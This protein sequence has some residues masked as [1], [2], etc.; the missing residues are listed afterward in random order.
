M[1]MCSLTHFVRKQREITDIDKKKFETYHS[2]SETRGSGMPRQ[3]E[4]SSQV[5][6]LCDTD[7]K[8][9]LNR[10]DLKM[11]VVMLFGYKPSKSETNMLMDQA[12]AK[13]SPG[14]GFLKLEDFRTAFSRVAPRLPERTVLEAFRLADQDSDGHVSFRDFEC[15]ISYGQANS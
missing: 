7:K 1:E 15:V 11:A 4:F 6:E 8:G 13:D 10:E 14:R 9:Y 5:Y 12:Q 2:C 3:A